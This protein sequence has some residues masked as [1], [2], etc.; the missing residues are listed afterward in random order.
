[1]LELLQ[2]EWVI[3]IGTGTISGIILFYVSQWLVNRGEN[4]EHIRQVNS[5]NK[6]VINLLTPY[7]ADKGLPEEDIISAII[8]SVARKYN[9]RDNEMYSIDFFCEELIS[10]IIGNVYISNEQKEIYTKELA[11]YIHKLN[12]KEKN[13]DKEKKMYQEIL[14]L[15]TYQNERNKRLSIVYSFA[16][17]FVSFI[18]TFVS[19]YTNNYEILAY[20]FNVYPILLIIAFAVTIILLFI[21]LKIYKKKRK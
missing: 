18:L 15:K 16:I 11:Q 10:S 19:V 21:T 6:E 13:E 5:A 17:S 3:G 9:I 1:M 14:L 12:S 4:K 7:I 2:N 8:N 20:P